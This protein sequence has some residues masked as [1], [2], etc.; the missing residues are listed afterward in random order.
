MH[1]SNRLRSL[2]PA[3]AGISGLFLFLTV[4]FSSCDDEANFLG[5]DILPSGDDITTSYTEDT[6]I[7]VNTVSSKP[8]VTSANPQMLLGS[9]EDEIFGRSRADILTNLEVIRREIETDFIIDSLVLSLEFS[10]FLGDSL[11]RQNLRVYELTDSLQ[12]DTLFY[13][14]FPAE[15]MY[16]NTRILAEANVLATD[17]LLHFHLS[18]P[19]L[20]SRFE[21]VNDSV[22]NSQEGFDLFFYG[23]YI[24][25]DSV[26]SPGGAFKYLDLS[27]SNTK[28][29][30]YYHLVDSV[31]TE[32]LQMRVGE[33]TPKVNRFMHNYQPGRVSGYINQDGTED[34]L[35]YLSAMGGVNTK[36]SFPGIEEWL[37]KKPIAI[38]KAE[39]VLSAEDTVY[40]GLSTFNYPGSLALYSYDENDN[41]Q[42]IYD[43]RVDNS[44]DRGFYDGNYDSQTNTYRFN[45]GVHLQSYIQ[46]DIDDLNLIL[47][48]S[49][50]SLT[51]NRVVLKGPDA[52]TN[53]M[54]LQ[55][56]YTEF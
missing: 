12:S 7:S 37:D 30:M 55:I 4:F 3:I 41:Y 31:D 32:E 49:Q 43:Y 48:S 51:A 6:E 14:D 27:S 17:T 9:Y 38:N 46:G 2:R 5:R 19:D 40:S 35:I 28:F 20:I 22:F 52:Q 50:S 23:F 21:E 29:S 13:S 36:I 8:V 56:S 45:I 47:L 54:K 44:G 15:G 10:G 11:Y 34:S 24:T 26:S 1:M 18:D 53:K 39:L 42:F 16:D 33:L 25:T